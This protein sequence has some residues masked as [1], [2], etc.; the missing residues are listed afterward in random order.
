[1]NALRYIMNA[2]E[3]WDIDYD[4]LMGNIHDMGIMARYRCSRKVG[5]SAI[6]RFMMAHQGIIGDMHMLNMFLIKSIADFVDEYRSSSHGGDM[7]IEGTFIITEYIEYVDN[8]TLSFIDDV[9]RKD[10]K[11][12]TSLFGED[13][14]KDEYIDDDITHDILTLMFIRDNRNQSMSSYGLDSY[15]MHDIFIPYVSNRE[16]G[17]TTL[18]ML[19]DELS[20]E[21]F[22]ET[23]GYHHTVHELVHHG[24]IPNCKAMPDAVNSDFAEIPA[25][26]GSMEHDDDMSYI[27]AYRQAS[28]YIDDI[29]THPFAVHD[30][31]SA[32]RFAV[33]D[34]YSAVRF[35]PLDMD[36]LQMLSSMN[37]ATL[38]MI[39]RD[40]HGMLFSDGWRLYQ[41]FIDDYHWMLHVDYHIP[42]VRDDL[43]RVMYGEL[44]QKDWGSHYCDT[45]D[46]VLFNK[47]YLSI[48]M[49]RDDGIMRAA[50]TWY[51]IGVSLMRTCQ[52]HGGMDVYLK[53]SEYDTVI[54]MIIQGMPIEFLTQYI[55]LNDHHVG[56]VIVNASHLGGCV[57]NVIEEG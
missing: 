29:R 34:D 13:M 4:E 55:L 40:Y 43:S 20:V 51:D 30:D 38:P 37:T 1:M 53:R 22:L 50:S 36:C 26:L 54:D 48:M 18:H 8:H 52:H 57:F 31:Y 6:I 16:H 25:V 28:Q 14:N 35:P 23:M 42:V 41:V 2:H 10:Y 56:K 5:M 11:A 12:T 21:S 45:S 24:H 47:A 27:S 3:P 9:L 39:I 46:H 44:P 33:H 49:S 17:H 15:S 32:V 19:M 7:S